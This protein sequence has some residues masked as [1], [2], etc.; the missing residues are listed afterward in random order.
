LKRLAVI[1]LLPLLLFNTLGYYLVFYGD[2]LEAK[3]E[4][5]VYIWGHDSRSEKMVTLSF[6][7]QDGQPVAEG[8]RFTDED[9]FI[10]QGRMYDVVS[11]AKSKDRIILTCYTD[12][13]ETALHQDLCNKVNA[14]NDNATSNHKNKSVLKEFVKDYTLDHPV[15]TCEAPD[16]MIILRMG[17]LHTRGQ[18][19]ICTATLSPPPEA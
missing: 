8:L 14:D 10:Y 11:T 6:P 15:L 12:T 1:S 13:K 17:R 2:L 19:D 3:H 9:E 4:A 5:E 16:L 7:V 18:A